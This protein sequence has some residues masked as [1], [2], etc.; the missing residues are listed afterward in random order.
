MYDKI[1]VCTVCRGSGW[2]SRGGV[3]EVCQGAGALYRGDA[4]PAKHEDADAFFDYYREMR[5]ASKQRNYG[6]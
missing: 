2:D 4:A 6:G 3:C 5:Y 1:R